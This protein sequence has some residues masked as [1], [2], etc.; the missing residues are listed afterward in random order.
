MNNSLPVSPPA[1]ISAAEWQVRVDLAACYRLCALK[2]WDDLIYTHISAT[3]PGEE[4]RFLINPFGWRFDEITASSLVK[5]DIHGNIIGD[6]S[7]RVN[8]TGFAI[9]GAVHAA[10]KD[11]MCVMHLHNENGVAVGMQKGGL[12]PLSQHA[13][14]FYEQMGYHDYEGLALSAAEQT[15]LI[16]RLGDYPAMLLRN[17]GTLVSGRTVAEAYVLMDTLDKACSFQ[18][19]AQSGGGPLN[20]PSPEICAKTYKELL[21]D[22]SPEGVLEWPALLR[23]LDAISPSYR[24]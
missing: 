19:K 6:Q 12:L 18:L 23:K 9:H 1:G 8:V 17:H 11:A 13:L 21:G 15:R 5:I 16:E 7:A 20:I 4:G 14:R 22:G 2:N 3:V 10:R 24:D